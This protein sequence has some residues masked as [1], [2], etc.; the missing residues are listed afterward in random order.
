VPD[1]AGTVAALDPATNDRGA[2]AMSYA[3][4]NM[5]PPPAQPQAV[6]NTT[7]A[8]VVYALYLASYFF[9]LTAIVGVVIAHVQYGA[10]D[11][12]LRTHYQFQIRTFWIGLLYFAVGFLLLFAFGIGILVLIWWFVWTLV[13]CIKGLLALN[14][15]RAIVQPESWLFG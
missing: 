14:E 15:G 1:A 7:L 6:S 9:G 13:R 2:F 12:M 5:P 4:P 8:M 10:A 11:P 3:D